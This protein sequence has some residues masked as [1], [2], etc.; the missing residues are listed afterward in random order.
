VPSSGRGREV[1]RFGRGSD[2]PASRLQAALSCAAIAS[3][4]G[5]AS[6]VYHSGWTVRLGELGMSA[7]SFTSKIVGAGAVAV[8]ASTLMG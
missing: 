7:S 6:G 1:G 8:L 3:A 2:T 5:Q 4:T